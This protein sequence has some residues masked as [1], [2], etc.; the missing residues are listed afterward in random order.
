[1]ALYCV[2]VRLTAV[3]FVVPSPTSQGELSHEGAGE[4]LFH[5]ERV[6]MHSPVPLT[7]SSVHLTT[8]AVSCFLMDGMPVFPNGSY[9]H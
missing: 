3:L 5:E 1:M 7:P 2:T 9:S 8:A 4:M 6:Q